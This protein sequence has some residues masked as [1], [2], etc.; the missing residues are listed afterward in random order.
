MFS[1]I[2]GKLKMNIYVT[3]S[4]MAMVTAHGKTKSYL[5]RFK[6]AVPPICAYGNGNQT[7]KHLIFA[8]SKL[9][10]ERQK[11][12]AHVSKQANCPVGKSELVNKYLTQVNQ[13]TNSIEYEK[14]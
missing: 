8:C 10:K 12:I 4:F 7:E 13:F 14:L 11:L 1:K 6:L 9:N 5:Y 2:K 3:P